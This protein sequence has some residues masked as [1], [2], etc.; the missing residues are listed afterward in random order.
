MSQTYEEILVRMQDEFKSLAGFQANDASDIGIRLKVLAGEIFSL[1]LN[2]DWI[3]K[4]MFPQTA[5]DIQLDYHAEERGIKRKKATKARGTLKFTRQ[6]AILYDAKIP[7]GTV[8]STAGADG[9]RYVTLEPVVLKAG[10]TEV[11]ATAEAEVPGEQSNTLSETISVMVTPPGAITG[12]INP[13]PF[14][15]GTDQEPDKDL[16]ER[17]ID[18]YRNIPN[19]TNSAFYKDCVLKYGDVYSAS[20]VS[21]ARGAGTVDI[22]VASRGGALSNDVMK[23]IQADINSLKEINVDAVV[24]APTLATIDVNIKIYPETG[25]AF[26]DVKPKCQNVISNYFS[27]LQIGEKYLIAELGNNIFNIEGVK[28]YRFGTA[29]SDYLI[30]PTQLASSGTVIITEGVE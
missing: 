23:N 27:S 17:L 15:G 20:V 16:R 26:S 1:M 22:Y 25:Y 4:E 13:L 3:K 18:S 29:S 30:T 6:R 14:T 19:G 24:K 12:V 21:R 7:A 9:L 11:Y 2:L 8:C 10:E 28:N 5:S